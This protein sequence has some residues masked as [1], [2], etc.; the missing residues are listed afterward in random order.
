MHY[1]HALPITQMRE[2]NELAREMQTKYLS[3]IEQVS[4]QKVDHEEAYQPSN[5][6]V[7]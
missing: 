4:S 2:V 5:A 7:Y 1:L 6:S 3:T